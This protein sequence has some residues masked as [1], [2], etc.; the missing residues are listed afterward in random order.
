MIIFDIFFF[1][2]ERLISTDSRSR[3]KSAREIDEDSYLKNRGKIVIFFNQILCGTYTNDTNA[4]RSKSHE[5]NT[6]KVLNTGN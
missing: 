4:C 5:L 2:L 1:N 3:K 6:L